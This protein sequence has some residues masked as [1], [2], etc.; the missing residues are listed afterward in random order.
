ML[1]IHE[2]SRAV[3]SIAS[4]IDKR[5]RDSV[6][7]TIRRDHSCVTSQQSQTIRKLLVVRRSTTLI[8][9][10]CS[11]YFQSVSL[12]NQLLE[13]NS[14]DNEYSAAS[15][16][17]LYR[18]YSSCSSFPRNNIL[19]NCDTSTVFLFDLNA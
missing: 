15:S 12:V 9:V 6:L 4:S 16:I 19:S 3:L 5:L 7:L 10:D 1:I 8:V 14:V 2:Q 11:L 13:V 17:F 18:N